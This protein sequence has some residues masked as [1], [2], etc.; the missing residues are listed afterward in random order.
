[1][2]AENN[3]AIY[4]RQIQQFLRGIANKNKK[5][6]PVYPDGIYGPETANAV[7]VF[8][9][10]YG[11][12]VTGEVNESTWNNL[13]L[14]YEKETKSTNPPEFI[15]PFPS[16]TYVL[17][18]GDYGYLVYIIQ[19]MLNSMA[20]KFKNL[21]NVEINGNFD[22]STEEAVKTFQNLSKLEETGIVDIDT[23]NILSKTFNAFMEP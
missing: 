6:P 7:R 14:E 22:E 2:A 3:K 10:E 5:I 20:D 15:A 16:A 18:K 21:P 4:V 23:W 13:I 19:I 1:M 12:P 17:K 11:L 8:Q 9:T